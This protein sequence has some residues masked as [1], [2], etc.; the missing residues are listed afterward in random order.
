MRYTGILLVIYR[1]ITV[2]VQNN[3]SIVISIILEVSGKVTLV[4]VHKYH[5]IIQIQV[6]IEL[7]S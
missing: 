4:Q 6:F 1:Y 3:I 7:T 5:V 2:Q